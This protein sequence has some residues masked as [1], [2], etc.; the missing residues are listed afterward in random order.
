MGDLIGPKFGLN[1]VVK[2]TERAST[3][4]GTFAFKLFCLFTAFI[5]ELP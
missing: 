2:K 4:I 1:I 5:S 3:G